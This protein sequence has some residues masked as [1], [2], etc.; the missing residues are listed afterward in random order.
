[1]HSY[2]TTRYKGTIFIQI[3]AHAL[4]DAHP[5]HRQAPDRQKW[6]KLMILVSK[7]HRLMMTLGQIFIPSLCTN[8]EFSTLSVRYY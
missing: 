4:I 7:M 3:G 5:L 1:M 2:M 8:S 6:V